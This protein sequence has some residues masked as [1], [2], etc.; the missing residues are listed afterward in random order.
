MSIFR[1]GYIAIL[2]KEL[3]EEL[4]KF[5]IEDNSYRIT[6]ETSK[7]V[8]MLSEELNDD[9]T[10]DLI[11][12]TLLDFNIEIY[13]D[14]EYAGEDAVF[15][16]M[17]NFQQL[18]EFLIYAE[19][20]VNDYEFVIKNTIKIRRKVIIDE[21]NKNVKSAKVGVLKNLEE[22][23]CIHL[24]HDGYNL[25]MSYLS[26]AGRIVIYSLNEL[27]SELLLYKLVKFYN[28]LTTQHI[29]NILE[30]Y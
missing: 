24:Y 13:I 14:A 27:Q 29:K 10:F 7:T 3:I 11:K 5:F 15:I 9:N 28:D 30:K 6:I 21:N 20:F 25:S 26:E 4:F 18:Q 22:G 17:I 12:T 1:E 23:N 8:D 16:F 19:M 2:P